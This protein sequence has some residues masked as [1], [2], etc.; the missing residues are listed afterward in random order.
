MEAIRTKI[1]ISPRGWMVR[2]ALVLMLALALVPAA[3]KLAWADSVSVSTF[4]QLQNAINGAPSG[5]RTITLTAN[6]T[7]TANLDITDKS[8][9][10]TSSGGELRYQ[11]QL[12]LLYMR[13]NG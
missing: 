5:G 7:P 4:E 2:I 9:T 12:K 3:P 10:L 11:I 13:G 6:I 1:R 8:I